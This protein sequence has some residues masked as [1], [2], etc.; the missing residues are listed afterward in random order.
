[1]WQF[2]PQDDRRRIEKELIDLVICNSMNLPMRKRV[3]VA[4]MIN[5]MATK[6]IS[7]ALHCITSLFLGPPNQVMQHFGLT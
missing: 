6:P 3:H 7:L 1:M 5:G 4:S 2:I